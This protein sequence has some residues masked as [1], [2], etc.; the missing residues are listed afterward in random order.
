MKMVSWNVNGIRAILKKNFL[1]YVKDEKMDILCLQET[2]GYPDNIDELLPNYQK[3]WNHSIEKKGYSGTSIFIKN[4]VSPPTRIIHGM[5]KKI[6]DQEGR[7]LTAEFKDFFLVCVYTPNSGEGLKRLNYRIMWDKDFLSFVKKLE[8]T[9]PVI[10]C[11]D[12][13]VAHHE[14]DIA[15]PKANHFTAGFTKEERNAFNR[16]IKN[17]L[18]DTFREFEKDPNHYTWWSY[19]SKARERNVGWRIDYFCVS[20]NLRN[21]VKSAFIHNKIMGSDHCPVGIIFA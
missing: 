9:N 12:L 4:N 15:R 1:D 2:R 13:N 7:M 19:K 21:Q 16:L 8:K 20:A 6:H 5:G 14:I 3:F 11:G 17:N 18:I 10:V